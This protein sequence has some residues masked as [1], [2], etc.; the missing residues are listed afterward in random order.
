MTQAK[1][2]PR[3]IVWSV[4]LAS[5]FV[6]GMLAFVLEINLTELGLPSW[7]L[8]VL[9]AVSCAL[10]LLMMKASPQGMDPAMRDVIVWVSLE[11]V[12]LIGMFAAW[13]SGNGTTFLPFGLVAV[14]LLA[15]SRPR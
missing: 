5:I 8:T 14:A 13:I 3:V 4:I 1:P 7:V 11:T 2:F 15:A 10:A 12:G 6:Y 9:A